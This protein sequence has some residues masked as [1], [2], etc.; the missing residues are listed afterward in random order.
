MATVFRGTK[1]ELRAILRSIPAVLAGRSP[2]PY[3]VAR[4]IQLRMGV[5]LLSQVQQDF[6]TKARGGTG[7]D[8]I[9]W[10]PLKPATIARRRR[11]ASDKRVARQQIAAAKQAGT[12]RPTILELYGSRPVEIGRDTGKLFRSLSPGVEDRP[13]GAEGQLFE[14]LPGTVIV[15]TTVPY[16][17]RF[18]RGDRKRNVPARPMWPLDG[19]IPLAWL[20]AIIGAAQ[21]GVQLAVSR[22]V[23]RR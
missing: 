11:S 21:R 12:K 5:A 1:S 18:H 6:V 4:D 9:T 13:S 15:G 2:D 20:P 16:A 7:R 19:S 14:V 23:G 10:A 22:L 8:G 17:E 3:G